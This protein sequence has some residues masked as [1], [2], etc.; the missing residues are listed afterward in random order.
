V[1]VPDCVFCGIAREEVAASVVYADET[2][3]AVLD[4]R[5]VNEGHTLVVPRRHA[6]LLAELDASTRAHVLEVAV[7]AG[8]ALRRSAIR[9]DGVLFWLADGPAAGQEIPHTHLHV[10][11]RFGGDPLRIAMEGG[12]SPAQPRAVLDAAAARVREAWR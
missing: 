5:P 11:P 9:C 4:L 10:V 12:W 6:E 8:E 7:A 3:V 1:P 2:C